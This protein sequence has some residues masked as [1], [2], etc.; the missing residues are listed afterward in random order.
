LPLNI[1]NRRNNIKTRNFAD[2]LQL[3]ISYY[4]QAEIENEIIQYVK[5]SSEMNIGL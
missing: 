1:S 2:V 5:H 3:Y 4:S